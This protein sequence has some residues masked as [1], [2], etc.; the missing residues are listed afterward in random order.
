MDE[1]WKTVIVDLL[2]EYKLS[3]CLVCEKWKVDDRVYCSTYGSKLTKLSFLTKSPAIRT[4]S[5]DLSSEKIAVCMLIIL[6]FWKLIGYCYLFDQQKIIQQLVVCLNQLWKNR[7]S[8]QTKRSQTKK[9]KTYPNRL[10]PSSIRKPDPDD[11]QLMTAVYS[12][13]IKLFVEDTSQ[14]STQ[15]CVD[16]F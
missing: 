14:V 6:Q 4:M 13:A 1:K 12:Q 11:R 3:F 7:T 5:V 15:C 8:A 10:S 16:I 2:A 9:K